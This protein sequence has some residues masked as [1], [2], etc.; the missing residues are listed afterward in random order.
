MNL[1]RCIHNPHTHLLWG[2]PNANSTTHT[3]IRA[4]ACSHRKPRIAAHVPDRSRAAEYITHALRAGAQHAQA[5]LHVGI[6]ACV[7]MRAHASL[8]LRHAH[9]H[10]NM[11]TFA[12]SLFCRAKRRM[13]TTHTHTH[14]QLQQGAS[15]R[16]NTIPFTPDHSVW[17]CRIK[18]RA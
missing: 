6:S 2:A 13:H 11:C 17:L 14:A 18:P 16:G 15:I 10:F 12:R 3:H 4:R 9:G 8:S 1:L 7:C 5:W